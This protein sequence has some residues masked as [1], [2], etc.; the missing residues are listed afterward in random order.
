MNCPASEY[1]IYKTMQSI[2]C[3]CLATEACEITSCVHAGIYRCHGNTIQNFSYI[4][5]CFVANTVCECFF[6]CNAT[7]EIE[8]LEFYYIYKR[9]ITKFSENFAQNIAYPPVTVHLRAIS[10]T[11]YHII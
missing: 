7:T 1:A 4:N 9:K 5:L 8:A 2:D 10:S 3:C 6:L 11:K